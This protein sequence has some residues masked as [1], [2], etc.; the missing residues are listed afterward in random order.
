[1]KISPKCQTWV[2][3]SAKDSIIRIVAQMICSSSNN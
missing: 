3:L 2:N 1:M